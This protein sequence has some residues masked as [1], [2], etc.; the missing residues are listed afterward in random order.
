MSS[1]DAILAS[2]DDDLHFLNSRLAGYSE[3]AILHALI[4]EL[5]PGKTALLTSFGAEAV[6]TLKLVSSVEPNLPVIFLDTG[7]H[8][9]ETLRYA[10]ELEELLRLT[11]LRIL[12]PSPSQLATDDPYGLLHLQN[13]DA[14]CHIRKV[15][16]LQRALTGFDACITGRKR[17]H[18]G[19]RAK[20]KPADRDKDGRLRVNPLFRWDSERVEAFMHE[21]DLPAH[22][23]RDDGY[24][25]IGCEPCTARSAHLAQPRGGRWS[26]LNKTECGIHLM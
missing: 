4:H 8:F 9:A 11:D 18:G 26:G 1:A 6:A 20:L 12:R 10:E 14:C 19:E 23:L 13:A 5:H 2:S 21:H 16:P 22:P 24:L 3:E 7:K 17:G 25:S 15:A